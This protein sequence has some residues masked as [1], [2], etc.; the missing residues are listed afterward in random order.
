MRTRQSLGLMHNTN[1]VRHCQS[2]MT[3][4]DWLESSLTQYA[5][6]SGKLNTLYQ[7]LSLAC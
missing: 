4:S 1:A 3:G 2:S 5:L 7:F 6:L